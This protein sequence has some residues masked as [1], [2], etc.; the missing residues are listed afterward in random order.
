M[1]A[2]IGYLLARSAWNRTRR[3]A[4]DFKQPGPRI[5]AVA[6]IGYFAFLAWLS[7]R[8]AARQH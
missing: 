2:A 1:S 4:S 7:P 3:I 6:A 5:A 8:M